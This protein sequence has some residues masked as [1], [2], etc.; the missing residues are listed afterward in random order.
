MRQQPLIRRSLAAKINANRQKLFA[1]VRVCRPSHDPE[2]ML[3]K[4]LRAMVHPDHQRL[5]DFP[6]ERIEGTMHHYTTPSPHPH[7]PPPHLFCPH[8]EYLN[9]SPHHMRS[10][11]GA[12]SAS[13]ATR[14]RVG[15]ARVQV[16]A[17]CSLRVPCEH[18]RNARTT[19]K[20]G[21]TTADMPPKR[22]HY[23][24]TRNGEHGARLP[25]YTAPMAR[26]KKNEIGG[27]RRGNLKT[28]SSPRSRTQ[29]WCP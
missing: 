21:K 14:K 16:T 24:H 29:L 28:S 11:G 3:T 9:K 27:W 1:F 2:I 25:S 23:H 15:G 4:P 22:V 12:S 26:T 19:T 20:A 6:A 8:S 17:P 10:V 18:E 13:G 5:S 7:T